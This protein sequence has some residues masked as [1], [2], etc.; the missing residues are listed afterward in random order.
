MFI[1]NT[2]LR[3]LY[4]ENDFSLR[5]QLKKRLQKE[6]EII[7]VENVHQALKTFNST[8]FDLIL[9]NWILPEAKGELFIQLMKSI[10]SD[11]PILVY[12]LVKVKTEMICALNS[13]A[14]DFFY[15]EDTHFDLLIAHIRAIMRRYCIT[16]ECSMAD[17]IYRFSADTV[18]YPSARN[19][20]IQ[21]E[22]YELTSM[23]S[24]LL[25]LLAEQMNRC[26]E[27]NHLLVK[28]WESDSFEKNAYLDKYVLKLRKCLTNDKS[29]RI[30]N[31]RGVGFALCN[32]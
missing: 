3:I 1:M 5:N 6:F 16:N 7:E 18:F 27:R 12:S 17:N 14:D 30:V 26:I 28:L 32:C 22:K 21:S 13:G 29:L 31:F 15:L 23:E 2:R 10:K 20:I 25:K 11:L 9:F 24:R 4:L 8:S 19:L